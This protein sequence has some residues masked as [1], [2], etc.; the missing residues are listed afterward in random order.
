MDF[1]TF[2]LHLI[3]DKMEFLNDNF[4]VRIKLRDEE[5]R[6]FAS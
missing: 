4:V 1:K 6:D 2:Q 5:E 3:N